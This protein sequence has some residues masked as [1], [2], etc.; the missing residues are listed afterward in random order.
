MKKKKI[1]FSRLSVYCAKHTDPKYCMYKMSSC[2]SWLL[3]AEVYTS[4][5]IVITFNGQAFVTSQLMST[6]PQLLQMS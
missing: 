6:V 5:F 2:S 1:C 3:H 4:T